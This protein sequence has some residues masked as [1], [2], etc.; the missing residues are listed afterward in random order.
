MTSELALSSLSTVRRCDVRRAVSPESASTSFDVLAE[1]AA[2]LVDVLDGEVDAGELRRA[3]DT[4]G[5]RSDGSSEPTVR[6]AVSPWRLRPR[7]V[8][9]SVVVA[10][11]TRG[12]HECAS[13]ARQRQD[14][15]S[16][17]CA[18]LILRMVGRSTRVGPRNGYA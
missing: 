12:Q 15:W 4:R 8:S 7:V 9:A 10:T 17:Y 13:S 6:H 5:H 1:N 16:W 11:A 14:A 3:E 2:G 18:S